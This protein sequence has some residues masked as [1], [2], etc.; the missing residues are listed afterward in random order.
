MNN[1]KFIRGGVTILLLFLC[2]ISYGI[3]I[4]KTQNVILTSKVYD[5]LAYNRFFECFNS[6]VTGID[7]IKKK[8]RYKYL[9]CQW[10]FKIK[11]KG[12]HHKGR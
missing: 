12:I 10:T 5:H 4:A 9:S 3:E 2:T 1:I 7:I 6:V 11:G 8:R